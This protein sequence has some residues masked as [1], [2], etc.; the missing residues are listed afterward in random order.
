MKETKE[1]YFV[2]M[3]KAV[4]VMNEIANLRMKITRLESEVNELC[5]NPANGKEE[6]SS[7]TIGKWGEE[8]RNEK[9][10]LAN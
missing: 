5:W 4:N 10:K 8:Y 7:E 2:R 3:E 6:V 1:E 9:E